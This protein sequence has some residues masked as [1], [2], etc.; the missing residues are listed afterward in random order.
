MEDG[1]V[2]PVVGSVVWAGKWAVF[3][4]SVRTLSGAW[5]NHVALVGAKEGRH[6]PLTLEEYHVNRV[7]GYHPQYNIVYFSGSGELDEK[8]Y[9]LFLCV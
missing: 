4:W 9:I 6:A 5:H 8:L 2:S 7:L 3:P 1:G